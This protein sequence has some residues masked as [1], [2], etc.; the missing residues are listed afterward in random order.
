MRTK[1]LT[2]LAA[3]LLL[4]S[5]AGAQEA[6]QPTL[7]V[8]DKAPP[9]GKGE[10]VKGDPVTEFESGKVYVI[11]NWATWCGPCIAAIPH[12]TELQK[13]YEDKGLVII[14]Q[15]M[16]EDDPSAVKPFVEKMG[17]KMGYRVVMDEP[18]GQEGYMA[19]TYMAAAGRNGIPCAFVIDQ[20]GTIAWI[21]HPMSM[22]PV[23]EKV[24]A[25]EYDVAKAKA[26]AEKAQ[27]AAAA[28]NK[29]RG[30]AQ[31]EKWDEFYAEADKAIPE[32]EDATA[33]N[34]LAWRIVDPEN[35]FPKQDL[36]VALK[37]ATKA[38]DLTENNS[39]M[40]LDTLARVHWLR[41]DRKKALELQEKAVK[42]NDE[43]Q[44]AEELA[45]RLEEY[46]KGQQE[47]TQ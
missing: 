37:A 29:L 20:K 26:D 45:A 11:E 27:R 2:M 14:G 40:I 39:G 18:S 5:T 6:A 3:V 19:R 10:W 28:M 4:A 43:A 34:E 16:W 31:E 17:D 13:K 21:G 24:L 1:L 8:G 12:V 44:F 30:L 36:D 15:N 41:G 46:R 9:L 35:P 47:R 42:V 22:E 23:L 33:L 7:K 25:G 38:S 32:I